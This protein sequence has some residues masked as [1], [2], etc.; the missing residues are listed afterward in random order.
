MRPHERDLTGH[1]RLPGWRGPGAK[2]CWVAF[3]SWE[4]GDRWSQSLQEGAEPRPLLTWR[5]VP[6]EL[7][8]VA[9]GTLPPRDARE[10][11]QARRNGRL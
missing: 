7:L 10:A 8:W 11:G 9:A 5:S 1:G 6:P 4:R 2:A 3:V